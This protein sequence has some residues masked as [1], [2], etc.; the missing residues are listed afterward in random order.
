MLL[1]AAPAEAARVAAAAA[2]HSVHQ[3]QVGASCTGPHHASGQSTP[4]AACELWQGSPPP[5]EA[6]AICCAQVS[7]L[8]P[9]VRS[10]ARG[11]LHLHTRRPPILHRDLK[12]ANVFVGALGPG[13][14]PLAACS[15]AS[16]PSPRPLR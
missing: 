14:P 12:P 11:M 8:L 16:R 9:L 6:D 15:H 13:L 2:V 3:A 7:R 1:G 4:H 5:T 10:I